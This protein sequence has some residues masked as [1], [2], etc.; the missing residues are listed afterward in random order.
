MFGGD[1]LNEETVLKAAR[2][3][4]LSTAAIGKLGPVLIFD[5]TERTGGQTI[6]FHDSTRTANGIPLAEDIKAA[7]TSAGLPP[8]PPCRGGHGPGGGF[9]SPAARCRDAG[10]DT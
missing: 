6:I 2:G 7:L 3:A 8:A 1:Y 4:S 10:S 9:L 5:H